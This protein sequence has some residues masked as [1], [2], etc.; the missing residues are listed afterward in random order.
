MATTTA[1][2]LVGHA[3]QNGSGINPTH[4]IQF[5]ENDR[6]ALIL[7]EIEG[8]KRKKVIIPTVE[9]TVDDIYLM[10]AVFIL[11]L[12]KPS[13]EIHNL[14][15][16]SLYEILEEEERKSL[17]KQTKNIFKNKRLKVVFN[18]L[19]D[20]HLLSQLK[21]IKKYPN[22]FEVTISSIKKEF[23]AWSNKIETK[24]I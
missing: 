19:D 10:I 14:E 22:D 1:T 20:S 8:G 5:T 24:G 17:Y 13:K 16:K 18:I 4:F 21:Q 23:N 7:R 6:P 15:R 12:I 11:K 3:H 9:N 2:I